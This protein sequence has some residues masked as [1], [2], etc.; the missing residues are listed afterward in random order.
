[1]TQT[2][3]DALNN[4]QGIIAIKIHGNEYTRTGEPDIIGSNKGTAFALE[5]KVGKNTPTL[6]Q[7]YRLYEWK[8]AGARVGL[9][10]NIQEAMEVV[11][12]AKPDHEPDFNSLFNR[13][14]VESPD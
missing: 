13:A 14:S 3:L 10:H 6:I 12:H 2:I 1:M 5:V 11:I 9:I 8:Q 4:I 7:I